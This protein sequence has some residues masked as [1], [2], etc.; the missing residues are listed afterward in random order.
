M[1]NLALKFYVV[2]IVEIPS[3]GNVL[4]NHIKFAN[5]VQ[6]F[7]LAIWQHQKNYRIIAKKLTALVDV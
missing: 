1:E 2:K 7:M 3:T 5:A 4:I 6:F